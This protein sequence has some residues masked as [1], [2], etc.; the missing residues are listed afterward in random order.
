MPDFK[1]QT[2][3]ADAIR[4]KLERLKQ[5]QPERYAE[6]ERSFERARERQAN[7]EALERM[8]RDLQLAEYAQTRGYRPSPTD[9]TPG[10]TVL[11][12]PTSRDRIAVA[13]TQDGHWIFAALP[14]YKTPPPREGQAPDL[15][16]E[17]LR[18]CIA[19]T[20]DKGS[21]VEFVQHCERVAGRPEPS[22]DQV[23]EHLRRWQD[24]ER[25]LG[26]VLRS[27]ADAGRARDDRTERDRHG[28]PRDTRDPS[29]RIGDWSPEPAALNPSAAEVQERLRRWQV[30]QNVV[31]EKL[32]RASELAKT[33]LA[34]TLPQRSEGSLDQRHA[35]VTDPAKRALA[36]RRY[37]WTAAVGQGANPLAPTLR[38]RGP[39]RGR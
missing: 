38:N 32:A 37:D 29:R 17:R 39:D 27:S 20:R 7:A 1:P 19:R 33:Q 8:K 4:Q 13:K 3:E 36:Q 25:E 9:S 22:V 23:R 16:R 14:D 24:R 34:P 21:V 28:E 30:A 15:T 18:D 35:L 26:L 12:H 2:S 31:D 11:E 10:V 5:D 6:L